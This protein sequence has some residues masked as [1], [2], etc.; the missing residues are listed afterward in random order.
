[1]RKR[2]TQRG[3]TL[4]LMMIAMPAFVLLV[5]GAL[6]IGRLANAREDLQHAA[7][8]AVLGASVYLADHGLPSSAADLHAADAVIPLHLRTPVTSQWRWGELPGGDGLYADV[9]VT[10]PPVASLG[11]VLPLGPPLRATARATVSQ[12]HFNEA[13]TR[14]P[15]LALVLDFSGSM[16]DYM[17][18]G[19]SKVQVLRDSINALLNLNLDVDIGAVLFSS[20]VIGTP[21]PVRQDP[22]HD[23]IRAAIQ[24]PAG[25]GTNTAAAI[26]AARDLLLASGEDTG[27]YILLASDGAPNSVP[28]AMSAMQ[29]AWASNITSFTLDIENYPNSEQQAFMIDVSGDSGHP[30]NAANHFIATTAAQMAAAFTSLTANI[31]CQIG[32]LQPPPRS[33]RSVRVSLTD[34]SGG[35]T[36]LEPVDDLSCPTEGGP[37]PGCQPAFHYTAGTGTVSLSKAACDL[38]TAGQHAVVRYDPEL[39]G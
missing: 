17:P 15:K 13:L 9:V 5:A 32:P 29:Q 26:L 22:R 25:G 14:R 38:V 20:D 33:P 12:N 35:Q 1:M 6:T 11:G 7:D 10:M 37:P 39:G 31:L 8:S 4:L 3:G 24:Q 27:Y 19:S 34:N 23:D 16:Q 21:L 36:V 2:D 18:G 28:D 30:G